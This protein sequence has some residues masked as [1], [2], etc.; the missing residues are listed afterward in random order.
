MSKRSSILAQMIAGFG[1]ILVVVVTAISYFSYRYSSNVLL[2]KS[3]KYILE[4]VIQMSGKLDGMLGEYDRL[5]LRIAYN[6]ITQMNL[7]NMSEGAPLTVFSVSEMQKAI[8]HEQGYL[9]NDLVVM[10][11]D[12]GAD[13]QTNRLQADEKNW[14]SQLETEGG[15]MMW[16]SNDRIPLTNQTVQTQME[17]GVVG[18]RPVWDYYST[19]TIGYIAL[20][21]PVAATERIIGSSSVKPSNKIQVIDQFG[22]VAYSTDRK[23]FGNKI[24]S[25]FLPDIRQRD[26]SGGNIIQRQIDGKSVYISSYTSPYSQWTVVTY[27]NIAEVVEDLNKMQSSILFIGALGIAASFC[28][29]YFFSWSLCL[30]I[31]NLA[32]RLTGIKRGKLTPYVGRMNNREV[33]VLYESFNEMIRDLEETITKLSYKQVRE[34]QARLI[35]LKAQFRPHFLYNSLNI[36]YFYAMNEKQH[37]VAK[38][39]IT[40]S[41]LL[42]YSIQ[43]GNEFVALK[44]DLAQ[45]DRFVELQRY[46]YEEKLHMEMKVQDEV[47]NVP[48]M[49]L[50]LQPIVENAFTHGLESVKG[51]PWIIQIHIAR[52][53]SM[54]HFVIEDNGSGMSKE[55]MEQA[56]EFRV[57]LE[58]DNTMH[59][60]VGLPNLQ[61]RIKL[62]Y[63]ETY[64]LQLCRSHLGGLKVEL[65]IPVFA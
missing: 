57:P 56:L 3:T 33:A 4:S 2:D 37:N 29:I 44:E 32:F 55:Q 63:G 25:A 60:G 11:L 50:L 34:N 35:A 8:T 51:R 21:I 17:H 12:N 22:Y 59:S 58:V 43:P 38:M 47:L 64:G 49:K 48:V 31:R 7:K 27:M 20:V 5:A 52:E 14:L 30:P 46:R 10:V 45:L 54:L 61:H 36:I 41:E 65:L 18:I 23:E 39:I 9:P 28:L 53:G 15:S 13:S 26:S 1:M 42:R 6:P 40:L 16:T 24:E 62:I 19:K